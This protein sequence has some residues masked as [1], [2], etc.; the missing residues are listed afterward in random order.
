MMRY[1]IKYMQ[2]LLYKC[3]FILQL[4]DPSRSR[5]EAM[6]VGRNMD[7][8]R[9]KWEMTMSY[10]QTETVLPLSHSLSLFLRLANCLCFCY[11]YLSI[12]SCGLQYKPDN[13]NLPL[14]NN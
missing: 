6:T 1:A 9:G 4:E 12:F 7:H 5:A 3:R 2:S 8:L 13:N 11:M 10:D 14:A